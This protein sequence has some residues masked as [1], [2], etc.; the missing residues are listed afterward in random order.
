MFDAILFDFDGVLADTEPVH[1]ECWREVLAGFDIYLEWSSFQHEFVGVSDWEMLERLG[2]ARKPP[3]SAQELWPS[4]SHKRELFQAR[5]AAQS[6]F[7]PATIDLIR[8]LR[9]KYKLAVVSS[10]HRQEIEPPL[11]RAGMLP[12][13]GALVCGNEVQNLKPAPEPYLRAAE[14]LGASKPLVIE[15]SDPG[16]ASGRAAGFEVLRIPNASALVAS[17]NVFL[18]QN[19]PRGPTK[20][21]LNSS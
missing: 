8:Q 15:D 12:F 18:R 5:I 21:A 16:V 19:A 3:I 1:F 4:Y 6:P 9:G 20:F 14:L 11:V 17:L 7:E 13:L 2:A 10:S